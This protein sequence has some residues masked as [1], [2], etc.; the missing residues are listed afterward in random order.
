MRWGVF[1]R[2]AIAIAMGGTSEDDE[3]RRRDIE[4]IKAEARAYALSDMT[5]KKERER[6]KFSNLPASMMGGTGRARR[7]PAPPPQYHPGSSFQKPPYSHHTNQHEEYP[8]HQQHPYPAPYGY[9]YQHHYQYPPYQPHY[10]PVHAHQQQQQQQHQQQHPFNETAD[11]IPPISPPDEKD[12]R[13]RRT[14]QTDVAAGENPVPSRPTFAPHSWNFDEY[15]EDYG[16]FVKS[17]WDDDLFAN[18]EEEDA[19][20]FHLEKEDEDDDENDDDKDVENVDTN[21]TTSR[22]SP[23]AEFSEQ[24]QKKG[25][26]SDISPLD[27]DLLSVGDKYYQDLEEELGWLEEEDM[28]AAVT[29]LLDPPKTPLASNTSNGGNGNGDSWSSPAPSVSTQKKSP[30]SQS[31]PFREAA[32]A[33]HVTETQYKRLQQL[34]R[35]HYQLLL[36][37]TVLAA[38]AAPTQSKT[39]ESA[40]DLMQ[41]VNHATGMLQDIDQHRRNAILSKV[42]QG[43]PQRLTRLQFSKTLQEHQSLETV[44]DVQGL[45]QL[46]ETFDWIDKSVEVLKAKT[47]DPSPAILKQEE[48]DKV[49][50]ENTADEKS[51]DATN[52]LLP[53]DTVRNRVF[54][55]SLVRASTHFFL[56]GFGSMSKG[57]QACRGGLQCRYFTRSTGSFRNFCRFRRSSRR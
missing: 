23:K 52:R 17:L 56:P 21:E 51:E 5:R 47:Q 9:P 10:P 33:T 4:R 57:I 50:N 42:Q 37:Q 34:F 8:P 26:S 38:R 28:E 31:T 13:T 32:R 49:N 40:S 2:T 39:M 20:E 14:S 27:P 12:S 36:Q 7:R 54:N 24:Q 43:A 41:I 55:K 25:P 45:K 46:K 53:T 29:T 6:A 15:D 11:T 1:E 16:R 19:D 44:F 18:D 30:R 48:N 22:D 35:S 3:A